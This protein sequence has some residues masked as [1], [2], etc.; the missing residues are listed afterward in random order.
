MSIRSW[1]RNAF[2]RPA[3]RTIRKAPRR[4]RLFLEVLEDRWCPSTITVLNIGDAPGALTSTGPGTYTAPTLRAAIAGANAMPGADTINFDTNGV[5]STA[6][7][8]TLGGTELLLSDTTG[9]TTITGP[10][11]GVTVSGGGHSRVFDVGGG[12]SAELS[13]LTITGGNGVGIQADG[14]RAAAYSTHST[15]LRR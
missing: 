11:A 12:A 13:G 5:F 15:A 9:A 3:V 6:Q 10:A 7:M 14:S 4:P 2:T 1:L 8:I